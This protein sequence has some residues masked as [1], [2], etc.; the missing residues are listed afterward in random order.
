MNTS[1]FPF[2]RRVGWQ[3]HGWAYPVVWWVRR[4]P[5]SRVRQWAWSVTDAIKWRGTM[6]Y[7]RKLQAMNETQFHAH[8][9]RRF[10]RG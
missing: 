1:L 2:L 6:R 9:S 8:I 4:K 10:P 7:W 3:V 5:R